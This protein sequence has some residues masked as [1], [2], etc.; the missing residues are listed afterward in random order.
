[1]QWIKIAVTVW[2]DPSGELPEGTLRN[3][4]VFVCLLGHFLLSFCYPGCMKR[5]GYLCGVV[6]KWTWMV[7]AWRRITSKRILKWESSVRRQ[8]NS[9]PQL[10]IQSQNAFKPTEKRVYSPPYHWAQRFILLC[11]STDAQ[12]IERQIQ[13][14]M[15]VVGNN[16]GSRFL[17]FYGN[18]CVL[19]K[20]LGSFEC[21]HRTS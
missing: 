14:G 10:R 6:K 11:A 12:G 15:E 18:H 2:S 19:W 21:L 16:L 7:Y 8:D 1:M 13:G 17:L 4:G 3:T 5:S 20:C 9:A